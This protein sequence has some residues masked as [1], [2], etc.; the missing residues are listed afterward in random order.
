MDAD[1]DGW[2]D[3]FVAQG[4]LHPLDLPDEGPP[5]LSYRQRNSLFRNS[6]DGSFEEWREGAGDA[7]AA[8]ESSRGA[9]VADV[10]GD[11]RLD[12]VVTNMNHRPHLL[13]NRGA[14]RG[15]IR[16]GLRGR[17]GNRDGLGSRIELTSGGN[18]QL[19]LVQRG[20]SYL[21][22]HEPVA[23]FGLGDRESVERIVVRWPSGQVST[24]E[25]VA[26]NRLVWIDEPAGR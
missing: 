5:G 14:K 20:G 8:V 18:R 21:S 6:G 19:R 24:L 17:G 1:H 9:A 11:G 16:V 7:L 12:I 3:M 13:I 22:S 10:N 15:W 4:H 25:N 2:E 23:H 26:P